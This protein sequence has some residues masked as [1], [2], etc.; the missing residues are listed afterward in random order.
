VHPRLATRSAFSAALRNP[1]LRRLQIAHALGDIAGWAGM[2]AVSV[3]AYRIGGATLLGLSSFPASPPASSSV[4]S[5]PQCPI[6]DH[7][8]RSWRSRRA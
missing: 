4:P 1:Q 7:G 6:G 2:T 8:R 3:Y 5:W